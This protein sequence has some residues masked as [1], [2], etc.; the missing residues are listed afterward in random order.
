M[1]LRHAAA[2]AVVGWYL[3]VPPPSVDPSTR[4]PTTKPNLDA[5]LKY[6]EKFQDFDSAQDCDSARLNA[7]ANNRYLRERFKTSQTPQ[8][9]EQL[10]RE[11]EMKNHWQKGFLSAWG[12][13]EEIRPDFAECFATD[14]PRLKE[15]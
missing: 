1:N 5:P 2:L 15:K 10:E 13:Y 3:M 7:P 14:D 6:W 4:L 12:R 11:L 9:R 8:Q